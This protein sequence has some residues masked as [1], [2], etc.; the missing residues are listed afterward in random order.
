M[1][2][3]A[4]KVFLAQVEAEILAI[5]S[6]CEVWDRETRTLISVIA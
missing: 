6:G 1:N 5:H 4:N 3:I 2:A